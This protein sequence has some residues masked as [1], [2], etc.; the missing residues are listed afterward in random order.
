M[1][2]DHVP[3]SHRLASRPDLIPAIGSRSLYLPSKRLIDVLFVLM[4]SP[5]VLPVVGLLALLVRMDGESAFFC[6]PRLGK[7]GRIFQLWK[8]RTMVPRADEKLRAHLD[9]DPAA[10]LEWERKQKLEHDPRITRVGKYLRKY[11]LDELPQFWNVLRGEMSLV[12]PRPM[13][14]EQ[15]AEYPGTA[16]FAMR[17]GL[18]GLW[19]ISD[20]NACS[21]AERAVHDTRYYRMMS[22]STDMWILSRTPLVV[23]RGTGL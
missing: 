10:R 1:S 5:M 17:P 3:H 16:Y 8:L 11:S 14:P 15:R 9:S 21:F 2:R 20:R 4:I 23:L 6:Q 22:L 7:N 12:G 13:L 18:T 19:Q